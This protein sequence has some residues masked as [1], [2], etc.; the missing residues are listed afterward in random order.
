MIIILAILS[1]G[2][3]SFSNSSENADK[4]T[5]AALLDLTYLKLIGLSKT[6]FADLRN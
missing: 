4:S 5:A 3:N 1:K 2:V 6:P